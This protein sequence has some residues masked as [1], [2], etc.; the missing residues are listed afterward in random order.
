M[1]EDYDM[2]ESKDVS[3]DEDIEEII[4]ELEEEDILEMSRLQSARE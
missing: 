2:E 3:F 4:P 1:Q